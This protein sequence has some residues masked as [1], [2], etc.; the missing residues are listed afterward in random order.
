MNESPYPRSVRAEAAAAA[1][2]LQDVGPVQA[3]LRFYR[4]HDAVIEAALADSPGP[5]ACRDGCA[6]CC[7]YKIEASA[8]EVLAIRRY[9]LSEFSAERRAEVLAR[10]ER[11]VAEAADLSHLEQLITN[12]TCPFLHEKSCSIYPVRPINCRSFH[13]TDVAACRRSVE[14]LREPTLQVPYFSDVFDAARGSRDGFTQ[15]GRA[16]GAEVTM[17]DLASAFVEAMQQTD[18]ET[19]LQAR[20]PMLA[21]AKVIGA[22]V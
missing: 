6:H 20:R 15:A 10:A 16:A 9:V 11:N 12:Q 21:R 4:R 2:D 5:V 3:V 13:S 7:Q 18:D 17:Y 1:A 22:P 19:A 8:A 14:E